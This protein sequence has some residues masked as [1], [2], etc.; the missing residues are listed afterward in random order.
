[1]K[2]FNEFINENKTIK[3]KELK[4][5]DLIV[6]NAIDEVGKYYK[7]N[8]YRFTIT[9]SAPSLIHALKRSTDWICTRFGRNKKQLANNRIGEISS[10]HR[11]TSN[12]EL[13]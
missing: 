8:K 10:A 13:K 12:F 1:M 6:I 5:L 11:I 3:D 2:K 9:T 4:E 7:E